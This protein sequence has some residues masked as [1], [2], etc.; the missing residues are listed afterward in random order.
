MREFP[1]I[2]DE[3][4]IT[5]PDADWRE[6]FRQL[7]QERK[8]KELDS[9]SRLRQKYAALHSGRQQ[10]SIKTID[11]APPKSMAHRNTSRSSMRKGN[12]IISKALKEAKTSALGIKYRQI[13]SISSSSSPRFSKTAAAIP[14]PC[15]LMRRALPCTKPTPISSKY[16]LVRDKSMTFRRLSS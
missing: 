4:D 16:I 15:P 11:R 14:P 6:A 10:K 3:Y 8:Q 13:S 1:T 9:S 5:D 7:D 2:A 12:S